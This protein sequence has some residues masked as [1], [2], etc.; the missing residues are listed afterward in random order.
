MR[1]AMQGAEIG[2]VLML[3]GGVIVAAGLVLTFAGKIPLVGR[4]PG[5]IV[6]KRGDFTVYL[7][8]ATSIV[9]SVVVTLVLYVISR[10]KGH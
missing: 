10:L 9:L 1:R 8:V 3:I 4:L 2:K 5:D 6:W 7:P